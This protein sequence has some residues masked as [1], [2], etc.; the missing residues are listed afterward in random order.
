[1]SKHNFEKWNWVQELHGHLG[2]I[3]WQNLLFFSDSK[4]TKKFF[5]LIKEV[6][7]IKH[8]KPMIFLFFGSMIRNNKIFF[9]TIFIKYCFHIKRKKDYKFFLHEIISKFI[10]RNYFYNT[11]RQVDI[12]AF[13][14]TPNSITQKKFFLLFQLDIEIENCF[15]GSWAKPFS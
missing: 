4:E 1:M 8:G 14:L 12:S 13:V 6:Y 10:C 5:I 2:K 7:F 15:G 11:C 3:I 9:L